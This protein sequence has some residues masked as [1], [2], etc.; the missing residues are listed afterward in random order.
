MP[1]ARRTQRER[2]AESYQR[3]LHAAQKVLSEQGYAGA[4]I[5]QIVKEAGYSQGAFYNHWSSKEQMVADLVKHVAGQQVDHLQTQSLESGNLFENLKAIS[6][7]PRLF[8]E[9]WLMAARG[10]PI[11]SFLKEHYRMWR[12]ILSEFILARLRQANQQH[13][14]AKSEEAIRLKAS[15]LIALFDGLLIQERLE[16]GYFSTQA[17]QLA[18]DD[19]VKKLVED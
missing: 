12:T 2:K 3:L 14:S 4:T 5:E 18:F 11:S 8:F 1:G 19:F 15:M 13:S 9:L 6:G 10:H 7:D 16:P 17:F